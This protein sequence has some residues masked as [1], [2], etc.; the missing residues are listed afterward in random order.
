MSYHIFINN[1]QDI[2]YKQ[3]LENSF[4]PNNVRVNGDINPE[5]VVAGYNKFYLDYESSRGVALT[6]GNEAYDIELNTFVSEADYMLAA[7]FAM[8]IARINNSTISPEFYEETSLEEFE[9]QFGTDWAHSFRFNGVDALKFIL[10]QSGEI[11]LPGCVRP[12]YFGNYVLDKISKDQPNEEQFADRLTDEIKKIQFIEY[13][14]DELKVPTLMEADFPEGTQ[15]FQVLLPGHKLLLQK[16][17][18]VVLRATVGE[19]SRINRQQF[20]QHPSLVL[21]RLDEA[22]YILQPI[23][24]EAYL[25]IMKEFTLTESEHIETKSVEKESPK[26]ET[27]IINTKNKW[28]QFRK[29]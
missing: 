19:I 28:W 25:D 9:I 8:A 18:W 20:I 29:R 17:D 6:V 5:D 16:S 15:T 7:K 12:F 22:Q 4:I 2:T 11:K 14:I 24:K 10:K 13:T 3:L 26:A 27:P 23:E 21:T 1:N